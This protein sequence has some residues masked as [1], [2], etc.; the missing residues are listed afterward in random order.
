MRWTCGRVAAVPCYEKRLIS[1]EL[2]DRM[3]ESKKK[4][5]RHNRR[6]SQRSDVMPQRR[7]TAEN[8]MKWRYHT[9]VHLRCPSIIRLFFYSSVFFSLQHE[10]FLYAIRAS[11]PAFAMASSTMKCHRSWQC[12]TRLK[13]NLLPPNA[14][15]DLTT[16]LYSM[17]SLPSHIRDCYIF[18]EI[19]W[20]LEITQPILRTLCCC[21]KYLHTAEHVVMR[22][23][24]KAN[25]KF[26]CATFM[27]ITGIVEYHIGQYW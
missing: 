9:Y 5:E 18:N 23:V 25:T 22:L 12:D 24:N 13:W 11:I 15:L 8:N 4:W 21:N 16:F 7:S 14:P 3:R 1:H 2:T 17:L 6:K 10:I 26:T 19:T 27:F 20:Q